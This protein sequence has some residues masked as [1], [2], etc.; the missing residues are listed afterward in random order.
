[1]AKNLHQ[2]LLKLEIPHVF[3]DYGPGHH[4]WPYW[5]RDL[6]ETLPA[7]M[8][9]FR[10]GSRPPARVTFTAVEPRYA[11]YGWSVSVK[12]PALEFSRLAKADRARVHALGQRQRDGHDTRAV[13]AP[14]DALPDHDHAARG[15]AETYRVDREQARPAAHR[16]CRSARATRRRSTRR[17]RR[18]GSSPRSVRIEPAP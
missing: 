17:A 7:I 6:K 8:A 2:R 14:R 12:R 15:A 16:S 9:R 5:N 11:V 18:R 13:Y 4:L 3:D 1:M 10:K